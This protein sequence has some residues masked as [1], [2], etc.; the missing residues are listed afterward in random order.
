MS[1]HKI[2]DRPLSGQLSAITSVKEL[3]KNHQALLQTDHRDD[4]K[5]IANLNSKITRYREAVFSLR[6]D[7]VDGRLDKEQM[8]FENQ[9]FE[10]EIKQLEQRLVEKLQNQQKKENFFRLY[11]EVREA[12][13]DMLELNYDD[14]EDFDEL[15]LVLRKLF[16]EITG[17]GSR[18]G[19]VSVNTTFGIKDP[20]K[21]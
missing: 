9:H 3:F 13:D 5:E 6:K 18:E 15:S 12:L 1:L 14:E 16:E 17:T 20:F 10:K 8:E 21:R 19:N 4:K 7:W 2:I 11:E